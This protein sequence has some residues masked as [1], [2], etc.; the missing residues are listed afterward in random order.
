MTLDVKMDRGQDATG[1]GT[2]RETELCLGSQG[3]SREAE[4]TPT[5]PAGQHGSFGPL[6]G[7]TVLAGAKGLWRLVAIIASLHVALVSCAFGARCIPYIA[8]AYLSAVVIWGG[9]SMSRWDGP[10][11]VIVG[12]VLSFAIQQ[13]AYH[14]W[15]EELGGF[16]WP[17]AQFF[18]MQVLIGGG[19][20]RATGRVFGSSSPARPRGE[21]GQTAAKGQGSV[22]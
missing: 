21:S 4:S 15:K 2:R 1:L 3:Y 11:G 18:A 17:L 19:G 20:Q 9:V 12:V 8:A 6:T 22:A 16:W 7:S 5:F 14:A 13:T 10:V